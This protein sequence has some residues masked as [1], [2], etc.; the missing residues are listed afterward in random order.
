M[1]RKAKPSQTTD[2]VIVIAPTNTNTGGK[3][4]YTSDKI[5]I[6]GLCRFLE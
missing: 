2:S 4:K 1:V 6:A 3:P 5:P